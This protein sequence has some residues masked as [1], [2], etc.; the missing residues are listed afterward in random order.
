[1]VR[2][3]IVDYNPQKNAAATVF[4]SGTRFII[5]MFSNMSKFMVQKCR[6][7]WNKQCKFINKTREYV[8]ILQYLLKPSHLYFKTNKIFEAWSFGNI[9]ILD[10]I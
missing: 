5:S 7:F 10:L 4:E 3:R 8:N 1:M 9:L 6:F 2:M